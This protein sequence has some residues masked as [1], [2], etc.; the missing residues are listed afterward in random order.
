MRSL[1]YLIFFISITT[2]AQTL[3]V[4]QC[5]MIIAK[6]KTVIIDTLRN[7]S[8]ILMQ[9][10]SVL[11]IREYSEGTGRIKYG[12]DG[13]FLNDTI[14]LVR[15]NPITG[16]PFYDWRTADDYNPE[17]IF[18]KCRTENPIDG[19]YVDANLDIKVCGESA[20]GVKEY[21]TTQELANY[22]C[23]VYNTLGQELYKGKYK[24]IPI[25]YDKILFIKVFI[26]GKGIF[27]IKKMI[28][29]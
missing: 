26:E 20:L 27:Y 15:T 14:P 4:P 11:I 8:T 24:N 22:T 17:I 13:T 9:D 29:K 19:P 10:N 28:I 7:N 2:F 6:G 1:I 16:D 5:G 12:D 23:A 3:E 21:Y 25:I 18:E